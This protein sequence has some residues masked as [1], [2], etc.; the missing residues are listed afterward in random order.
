M[1]FNNWLDEIERLKIERP[2]KEPFKRL[3]CAERV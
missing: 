1:F 3:D 2:S